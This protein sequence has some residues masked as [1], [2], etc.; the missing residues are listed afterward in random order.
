MMS[1]GVSEVMPTKNQEAGE[2]LLE[3]M[4]RAPRISTEK[5]DETLFL[6]PDLPTQES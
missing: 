4:S 3:A 6:V 5:F 1:V 2:Q